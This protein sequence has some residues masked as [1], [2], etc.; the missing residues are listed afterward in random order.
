[1]KQNW[2]PG[3]P[4]EYTGYSQFMHEG[5]FADVPTPVLFAFHGMGLDASF[6]RN[7]ANLVPSFGSS[8]VIVHADAL[9][10]PTMW[11]NQ[12]DRDFAFFDASYPLVFCPYAGDHNLWD[13]APQVIF[14]FFESL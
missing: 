4:L 9:G 13:N 11:D 2:D 12:D 7:W 8:Y 5:N 3:L 10:D 14:E 6:F 1:M